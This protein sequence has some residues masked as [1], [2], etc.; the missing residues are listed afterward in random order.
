M[1]RPAPKFDRY[2]GREVRAV[3]LAQLEAVSEW[4]SITSAKLGCLDP[5][6]DKLLETALM[7]EADC[8]V[9]GDRDLLEMSP[10]ND[11]PILTPAGFL[12][13]RTGG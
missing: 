8:L 1:C 2:V 10:F 12:D 9:A 13:L 7:G 4:V 5:D 3:Y 11:I 6:D